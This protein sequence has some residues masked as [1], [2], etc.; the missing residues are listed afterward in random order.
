MATGAV[1]Q[2]V[3]TGDMW[4]ANYNNAQIKANFDASPAGVVATKGDLYIGTGALSGDRLAV[5][6]DGKMLEA[7]A[8]AGSTQH[9][10]VNS[11]LAPVGAILIWSGAVAA[12]PANWQICDGT[13][14]TPDLRDR[15]IVGS[16]STYATGATGG[17]ATANLEHSH[18]LTVGSG[19]AH[20]HTQ[21]NTSTDGTHTHTA[22]GN[23]GTTGNIGSWE[24]ALSG[25][26]R[27]KS[28]HVHSIDA[29]TLATDGSHAHTNPSTD[30]G[31][32]HAHALADST[33]TLGLSAAQDIRPPYYAL[34]FIMR[35]T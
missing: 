18:T 34:A 12:I 3:S 4:T 28:D 13:G 30:S 2:T 35:M 11:G 29:A 8:A 1:V 14:G 21:P 33:T 31:G 22:T 26:F 10:W 5:G 16:G 6:A 24:R 7:R 15:F 25:S 20:T 19:G 23:T 27:A 9:Q 32:A 17:A